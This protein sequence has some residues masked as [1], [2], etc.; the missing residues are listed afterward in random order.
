[1]HRR[2]R[3][4]QSTPKRLRARVSEVG[5]RSAQSATSLFWNRF[6]IGSDVSLRPK[7]LPCQEIKP[8]E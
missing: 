1:M 5:R 8:A 7:D 3:E 2:R 6:Q 4:A